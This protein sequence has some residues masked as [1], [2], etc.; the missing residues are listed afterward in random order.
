MKQRE[1]KVRHDVGLAPVENAAEPSALTAGYAGLQDEAQEVARRFFGNREGKVAAFTGRVIDTCAR[2]QGK[3]FLLIHNPGG[4]GNR[5]FEQCLDW[6]RSL[7]NGVSA[8]IERLGYDQLMIQYLR[9]GMGWGEWLRDIRDQLRFFAAKAKIMAAELELVTRHLDDLKV[10][11][12][13]VSQGAAFANAVMRQLDGH[14]RVYSIELGMFFFHLSRRVVTERT[15]SMDSNGSEPDAA[16]RRDMLPV[17]R[18]YA[19]APVRW[20]GLLLKG[21]PVRFTY[22]V[23]VRGH[24]YDWGYPEVQKQVTDF[25]RANFGTANPANQG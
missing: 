8:A 20:A 10:I 14:H 7:V 24:N 19:A 12:I 5:T 25:L 23:N 22:C 2:A 17:F 13:G 18:A 4:W 1:S 15:L 16:V 9:S 11:L 21:R 6:E 3:D